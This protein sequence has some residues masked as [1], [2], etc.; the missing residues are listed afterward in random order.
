MV[1]SMNEPVQLAKAGVALDVLEVSNVSNLASVGLITSDNLI[2]TNPELV[3]KMVRAIQRGIRDTIANPDAAFD[4][5]IKVAP[6]AKGSDPDLSRQ[7]LKETVKFMVSDTVKGQPFGYT[8]PKL[9]ASSEQF[10]LD[11]K[12]IRTP[13]DPTAAYT[14]QFIKDTEGKY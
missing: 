8:D 12:L 14:N 1:Y 11:T 10:L 7:V 3:Q 4:S 5:T 9:W 6:D 13:V 2:N